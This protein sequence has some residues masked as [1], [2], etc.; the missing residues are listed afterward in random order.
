MSPALSNT[1]Y[2]S[3]LVLSVAA[4]TND[5]KFSGLQQQKFVTELLSHHPG[6]Q[7]SKVV[8]PGCSQHVGRTAFHLAAVGNNPLSLPFPVS[9]GH[10]HSFLPLSI[11][12]HLVFLY[13]ADP[14][15]PLL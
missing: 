5:R 1:S 13:A 6:G 10:L 9:E 15:A 4:V 12:Y 11:C 3:I 7:K 2:R 14:P 8:F